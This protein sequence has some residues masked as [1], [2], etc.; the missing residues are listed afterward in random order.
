MV[1]SMTGYGK[2]EAANEKYVFSVELKAVNHRYLDVSIRLPKVIN[3]LESKIRQVVK[4]RLDRGKVD[5]FINYRKEAGETGVISYDAALVKGYLDCF[6]KME[7]EFGI[8]NDIKMSVISRLPNV[9]IE[10]EELFEDES[11]WELL[12][13]A[14][15]S[16]IDAFVVEREREG[17]K[18]KEDLLG[19]LSDL[20]AAVEE[21]EKIYP[22]IL[23]EYKDKLALKIEEL[24]GNN[25]IE[26]NRILAEV[27]LYADKT[28]VD[29][30]TVRLKTHIESMTE[31]LRRGGVC[32]KKLDF[33]T[34]EMNR[35][36]NTIL[37]KS[38]TISI[39]DIGIA[40]K[41]GIEK[42]REQIQNIE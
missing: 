37:S 2:A 10:E 38:N 20:L 1:R 13:D 9:I 21:I 17:E 33:I 34:Q 36:A 35:E 12:L 5:I 27:T 19:K 39:T 32:G 40:L 6:S 28:C 29:E 8:V 11:V 23:D 14:L 31:T 42:V 3:S 16:A 4:D 7:N 25:T 26:E 22:S 30:E 18:L 41:T 15:N 24:L